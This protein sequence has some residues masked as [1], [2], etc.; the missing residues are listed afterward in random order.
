[1]SEARW[2][3]CPYCDRRIMPGTDVVGVDDPDPWRTLWHR[4][5]RK[6]WTYDQELAAKMNGG[7]KR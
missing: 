2:T 1:M 7:A 6:M 3:Y 4:H 5:C